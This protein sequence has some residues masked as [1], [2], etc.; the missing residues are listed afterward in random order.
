ML[1]ASICVASL[2]YTWTPI[3]AQWVNELPA[4]EESYACCVAGLPNTR[5][6]VSVGYTNG[7]AGNSGDKPGGLDISIRKF[8][9]DANTGSVMRSKLYGSSGDEVA[10]KVYYDD[11][12]NKII[13]LGTTSG[14]LAQTAE[15][16]ADLFL[17]KFNVTLEVEDVVQYGGADGGNEPFALMKVGSSYVVLASGKSSGSLTYANNLV[18]WKLSAD[19]F[20]V[21][22]ATSAPAA[23][24]SNNYFGGYS[25][26][27]R[28]SDGFALVYELANN[29][30][31]SRTYYV[32]ERTATNEVVFTRE[33]T[34]DGQAFEGSSIIYMPGPAKY[35]IGGAY[36]GSLNE[37]HNKPSTNSTQYY[38]AA[39]SSGGSNFV[40]AIRAVSDANVTMASTPVV[41]YFGSSNDNAILAFSQALT[42]D[43]TDGIPYAARR[44]NIATNAT[45]SSFRSSNDTFIN[46]LSGF[47]VFSSTGATDQFGFFYGSAYTLQE[48]PYTCL[49]GTSRKDVSFSRV[50]FQSSQSNDLWYKVIQTRCEEVSVDAV[51]TSSKYII[52]GTTTGSLTGQ[53]VSNGGSTTIQWTLALTQ[54]GGMPAMSPTCDKPCSSIAPP[55]A[56][57]SPSPSPSIDP[58]A[59]ATPSGGVITPRPTASASWT[60][61]P[62][63]TLGPLPKG[64]DVSAGTVAGIVIGSVAGAALVVGIGAL[65]WKKVDTAQA[66]EEAAVYE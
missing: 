59:T 32:S 12:T 57:P 34:L 60:P 8:N 2:L 10:Y 33:L 55:T 19:S 18:F 26:A 5:E 53:S 41:A 24:G 38:T 61:S 3:H 45:T 50:N 44:V 15:S 6:V 30:S 52:T 16:P 62:T 39:F 28:G 21:E 13:L 23:V 46:D 9:V 64:D 20:S 14:N 65:I 25:A 35:V 22:G 43:S 51:F 7:K 17:A 58:S 31:G 63:P 37:A 56:S 66:A 4:G 29:P 27:S 47:S 36:P 49:G 40:A 11:A 1:A 54:T 42:N 48:N